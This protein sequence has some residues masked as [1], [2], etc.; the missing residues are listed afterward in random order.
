MALAIG[1]FSVR[2]EIG[3]ADR[4][5]D[6]IKEIV[7]P[8][9][10]GFPF[11]CS[12]VVDETEKATIYYAV[13]RGHVPIHIDRPDRK[14][15]STDAMFMFVIQAW[16]RPVLMAA[17]AT[18][19][20]SKCILVPDMMKAPRLAL[21]AVELVEGKALHMDIAKHWHGITGFPTGDININL[22][23]ESVM[24]QVPWE[25]GRDILGALNR[26]KR[27]VGRDE[28]FKDLTARGSQDRG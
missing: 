15:R 25:D 7:G 23:P 1:Y 4:L 17:P 11:A 3:D 21:G 19:E 5:A 6:R 14:D 18:D 2:N 26:M 10:M 13:S 12:P 27:I 28:R 22:L 24:I 16:N 8:T 9:S 20:A